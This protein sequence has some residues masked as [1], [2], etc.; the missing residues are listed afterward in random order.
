MCMT[1]FIGTQ[2]II[3][4]LIISMVFMIIPIAA[5]IDVLTHQFEGNN[6][7]IWVL[8]ILLLPFLGSLI[9]LIVGSSQK[10]QK[11]Q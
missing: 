7:L 9:Y 10:I 5:L 2:E 3:I 8:V 6:K 1:A 4:I 11:V